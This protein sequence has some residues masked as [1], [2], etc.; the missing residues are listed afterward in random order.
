MATPHVAAAAALLL[1]KSPN[2]KPAEIRA[3]LTKTA[4]RVPWQSARPD[5][6]Y[7]YGRLNIEAALE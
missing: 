1:A 5:E 6:E 2:L 7:G 3:Q 4:D